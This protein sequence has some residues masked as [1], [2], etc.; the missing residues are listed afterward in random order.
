MTKHTRRANWTYKNGV[1]N[2]S[3]IYLACVAIVENMLRTVRI[4]DD[5]YMAARAII[6][7]LAHDAGLSPRKGRVRPT[8]KPGR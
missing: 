5:P 2:D 1:A 3:D 4:G 8:R 6:S 7:H